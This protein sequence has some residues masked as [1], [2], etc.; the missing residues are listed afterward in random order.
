LLEIDES[1]VKDAYGKVIAITGAARD[2]TLHKKAEQELHAEKE[3]L[4]ILVEKSPLGISLIGE[5]GHYKY[6]NPKFI[7]IFGYTLEDIPAGKEW[8][9]RAYPD[10]NY[11]KEV[12]ATWLD[13]RKRYGIGEARARTYRATCKD[14]SKKV[15][16]FR[17]V[18]METGDQLVFYED[19]TEIQ[20]LEEQ[21]RQS[22][23][24]EAIGTLAGGIAHDFNNLLQAIMGYAQMIMMDKEEGDADLGRLREIEKAGQRAGQLTKQLLTFSRKVESKLRPVD[25][26]QEVW[27]VEGLL[28]R[29]I[30]KMITIEL[31]LEE[32]LK[33][34]NADPAQVEQIMMNLGV[35]ARDAMPEGGRL[36][37]E[38]ETINLDKEYCRAHLGAVPGEYVLLSISDTGSGM[39]KETVEHI[40]E[41]FYTT[42]EADK[43]TGLGLSMVY[44][45]VKSHGG[46]IMCYSEPG[47]GTTFKIYLPAI[48]TV[49]I[50]Y[51]AKREE[52]EEIQGGS[53]TILLVDDEVFLQDLGKELLG[54]FGYTVLI[55]DRGES[56]LEIYKKKRDEISLVILDIIMPGMGGKKCLEELLRMNPLVKVVFTSGYSINGPTREAPHAGAKGFINKPYELRQMLKVVR[57]ALDLE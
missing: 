35:N 45:I 12:I 19:I 15:I 11:R 37:I 18:S 52:Q 5:D 49:S 48:E 1:P 38:T 57:E 24:M 41:P 46:Y 26:N 2:V 34:I 54:R 13:D 17:T 28:K 23:K 53:E 36:V 22:Q 20:H 30:P 55:A 47:E 33:V 10:K 43:G 16:Y 31:H 51:G 56:A 8:F 32:G 39:D 40:F 27:Q 21:L 9:R 14:G 4:R 7:E 44:G 42:K 6:L 3:R 50:E 29:I 25:L